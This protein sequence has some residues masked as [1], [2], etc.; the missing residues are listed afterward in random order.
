MVRQSNNDLFLRK[1]YMHTYSK[2]FVALIPIAL[3]V[4]LYFS[5]STK[6]VQYNFQRSKINNSLILEKIYDTNNKETNL[7]SLESTNNK[8]YLIYKNHISLFD[9]SNGSVKSIFRCENGE[10]IVETSTNAN[11]ISIH[12]TKSSLIFLSTESHKII[13]KIQVKGL[14]RFSLIHRGFD[15]A[16]IF[17]KKLQE[18]LLIKNDI[19]DTLINKNLFPITNDGAISNDGHFSYDHSNYL[20]YRYNY[21]DSILLID[22]T[23]KTLSYILPHDKCNRPIKVLKDHMGYKPSIDMKVSHTNSFFKNNKLYII[24][25]NLGLT[26]NKNFFKDSSIIDVYDIKKGEYIHS[27][28]V[29]NQGGSLIDMNTMSSGDLIGLFNNGIICKF[30]LL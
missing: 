24:S 26:E 11:T 12:I 4:G 9:P 3:L 20:I 2:L 22:L 13:N 28:A 6:V 29:K 25:S 19:G 8:F 27:I 18:F 7:F 1:T 17:E 14:S 16:Y 23:E 30:K 21:R 5:T 10:N 15:A